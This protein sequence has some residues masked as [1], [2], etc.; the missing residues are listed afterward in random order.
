MEIGG[1]GLGS[2]FWGLV[3]GYTVWGSGFE[4]WEFGFGDQGWGL[5]S[6]G[7]GQ[8]DDASGLH[9]KYNKNK[10]ENPKRVSA[11]MRSWMSPCLGS[12]KYRSRFCV[13]FAPAQSLHQ[14][15]APPSPAV[16]QSH[17]APLRLPPFP[18]SLL[19]HQH[20]PHTPRPPP[21]P[22]CSSRFLH[23]PR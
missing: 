18:P 8:V 9:E 20:P 5:G 14:G 12:E 15:P 11:L 10:I 13:I 16:A 6:K 4:V 2:G 23:P 1:R 22:P 7:V 3:L 19:H 21:D 17:P